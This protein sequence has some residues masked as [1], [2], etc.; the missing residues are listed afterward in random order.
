VCANERP[1]GSVRG[2]PGNRHPYR[3]RKTVT[4]TSV[5]NALFNSGMVAILQRR[6]ALARSSAWKD[7]VLIMLEVHPQNCP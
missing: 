2:V 1:H 4:S 5:P 3:D 7:S 6:S